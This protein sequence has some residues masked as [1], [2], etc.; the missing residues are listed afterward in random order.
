MP[1]SSINK[2]FTLIMTTRKLFIGLSIIF[3]PL[4]L[5]FGQNYTWHIQTDS[6]TTIAKSI[7]AHQDYKRIQIEPGSFAQWLRN[8]PLKPGFPPV[9]LYSK[10]LKPN[11]SAN[12][13]VIDIDVGEKNLQQ[14]ADAIIRL[15][16][17]YLF[18]K[19]YY[20]SIHFNFTSGDTACFGEWIDGFRPQ[21]IGN[22][23][24][25]QKTAPIDSSYHNFRNYLECVMTYAGTYSFQK[26]LIKIEDISQMRIGDVFIQG[27]FPSH[28]VIVVDMAEK[29]SSGERIFLLAQSYMPAQDIH[30]LKSFDGDFNPWYK[31]D[32]GDILRTPEWI[33]T[34]N[35]LYRFNRE[36]ER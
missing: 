22:N 16:A 5:S 9:Y 1:F 29:N 18:S 13:A 17:E 6:N 14:C 28:A 8:L 27:G 12:Y 31:L 15:R 20:R 3:L 33:F 30:I 10:K 32:F 35:D 23:V 19:G 2:R 7:E 25:W 11:Q 36:A 26:E 34:K 24:T 21:V 4:F